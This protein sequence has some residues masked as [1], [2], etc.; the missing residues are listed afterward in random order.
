VVPFR[1]PQAP[2]KKCGDLIKKGIMAVF[3][4][5]E[6]YVLAAIDKYIAFDV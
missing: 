1:K 3:Y 4:R 5:V 6:T 2:E